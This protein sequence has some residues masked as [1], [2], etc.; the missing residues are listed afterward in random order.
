MLQLC[1]LC[2][3]LLSGL[4]SGAAT[5]V[6]T[7]AAD[8]GPGTLRQLIAAAVSGTAITFATNLSGAI[9]TLASGQLNVTN[10]LTI[11]ASVLTNGVQ[12]NGNGTSRIFNMTN[13]NTVM[14]TA[15][16]ITNGAALGSGAGGGIFITSGV[17]TLN[18][19]TL[20]ANYSTNANTGGGGAIFDGNSTLTLNQCTLAGNYSAYLGGG[21]FNSGSTLTLNQCTMTGNY[22]T[23]TGPR[24]GGAICNLG[25]LTVNQSTLTGNYVNTAADPGGI[26]N[27]GTTT[28]YN[29]IVAGNNAVYNPSGA[30]IVTD[31][32]NLSMSGANIVQNYVQTNGGSFSGNL[33]LTNAPQLGPLGSYGGP[34]QTMPPLP[35]SPAIDAGS[36]SAT[37]LFAIDQRGYPRRAGQ[38]VD[39]GAME[40]QTPF[41]VVTTNADSGPGSLRQVI[42][43]MD[44]SATTSPLPMRCPVPPSCSPAA[45]LTLT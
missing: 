26:Y 42:S 38:H 2:V 14:L 30:D 10:N 36:D 35:G 41:L 18:Q 40:L 29:S 5:L 7:N 8:S 39:I 33:P 31:T 20:T 12:I 43:Q 23:T 13:G 21:I 37:N 3:A 24:G 25:T 11:D 4:T 22:S 17:L 19:C 15:L 32:L 1:L 27:H 45:N 44:T 6:V 16:T 9:I 34:A 28:L